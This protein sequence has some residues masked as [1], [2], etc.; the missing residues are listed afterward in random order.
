MD[1]RWERAGAERKAIEMGKTTGRERRCF[2]IE[3]LAPTVTAAGGCAISF[4]RSEFPPGGRYGAMAIRV[5][6]IGQRI[7]PARPPALVALATPGAEPSSIITFRQ[8]GAEI[9]SHGASRPLTAYALLDILPGRGGRAVVWVGWLPV[10]CGRHLQHLCPVNGRWTEG[11]C[12]VQKRAEPN[13]LITALRDIPIRLSESPSMSSGT[14]I[15][16]RDMLCGSRGGP[17]LAL[18]RVGGPA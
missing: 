14:T 8:S 13:G 11:T 7:P 5:G 12:G 1:S 2:K 15:Y 6:E 4:L 16:L 3:L 9:M 10:G 17:Y 18:S